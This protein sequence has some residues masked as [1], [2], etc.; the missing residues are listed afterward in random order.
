MSKHGASGRGI[1]HGGVPSLAAVSS[2]SNSLFTLHI[3]KA[4]ISKELAATFSSKSEC[5]CGEIEI[6]R[7]R[8]TC[9]RTITFHT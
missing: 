3:Y 6:R 2:N 9:Q 4:T 7:N 1:L 8:Y 5:S